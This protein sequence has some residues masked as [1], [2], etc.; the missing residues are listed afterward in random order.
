M[1]ISYNKLWNLVRQNKM[2]KAELA[3]AA[4]ISDYM[5]SKLN[6]DE[7]VQMEIMIRLCKVFHCDIGDLMEVI[8]EGIKIMAEKKSL[9][10]S[11]LKSR[12]GMRPVCFAATWMRPNIRTLSL[13]SSS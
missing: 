1:A 11:D 4:G 13:A 9:R 8:E 7:P 5:M 10:I 2:K 12:Y 3:K 6:K